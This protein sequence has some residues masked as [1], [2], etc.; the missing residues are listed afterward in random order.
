MPALRNAP[1]ALPESRFSGHVRYFET[2]DSTNQVA[3]ELGRAGEPDGT[4]VVADEQTGGR[5]RRRRTWVSPSGAG[6]YVSLLLRPPF[7]VEES[8][9]AAQLVGGIVV[10]ECAG[11]LL[12]ERPALRW[13]NDCYIDDRKLAGV[14]VEAETTG[15]QFDFLVCG[16]GI[17]V[18]DPDE[19]FPS[20]LRDRVTTLERQTGHRVSRFF[21]LA[22]LLRA[23]ETWDDAWR[24]HGLAPIV[25]R[26]LELSPE[27]KGGQVRVQTEGG[28]VEG[29]ADGLSDSGHLRVRSDGRLHELAVGEVVR[30]RPT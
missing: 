7:G 3:R 17:N 9:V 20:Q 21:V 14:L 28:L 26:W 2:V 18:N 29:V 8:G 12:Q 1:D 11:E 19:G 25:G 23:F 30:L 10:A 5:G 22:S 13:P 15:T 24:A 4:V 16:I 6:L 27:S